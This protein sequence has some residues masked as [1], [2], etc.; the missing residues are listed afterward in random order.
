MSA[1]AV[2]REAE[3]PAMGTLERWAR[4]GAYFSALA[5]VFA[6]SEV[7]GNAWCI[8]LTRPGSLAR[9]RRSN[10]LVRHWGATLCDLTMRVLRSELD[11]RGTVPPGR[12]VV[13]SNHQSTADISILIWTLRGLNCKFVAK[14]MLGWG[15]PAVSVALAKAGGAL[16]SRHASRRD[17]ARLRRMAQELEAWD[18]SAVLFA[19][20]QRARDGRVLPYRLAAAR[21]VAE[22]SRLPLLP[23]A[24]DGTHVASDLP[25]FARWMPGA[26]VVLTLGDPVPFERW[27]GRFEETLEEIRAWAVAT[28]E[29]A[30]RDGSI[31]PP[32]G[33]SPGLTDSAASLPMTEE[34]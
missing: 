9:V 17:I 21:I 28:I 15:M 13:V 14:R 26:R 1:T 5:V 30:R 27:E 22:E 10:W 4:V 18:G 25:G 11:L 34:S 20:G 8:W 12:Y 7:I 33:W 24:I 2:A 29:A 3:R 16:I 6:Y 32:P 31:A 23:I 19:E